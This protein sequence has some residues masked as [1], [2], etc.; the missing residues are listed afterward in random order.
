MSQYIGYTVI[1][2]SSC[3][4]HSIMTLRGSSPP[5]TAGGCL[6]F[7]GR[8]IIRLLIWLLLEYFTITISNLQS[9]LNLNRSLTQPPPPPPLPPLSAF[10][11]QAGFS[12]VSPS[13]SLSWDMRASALPPRINKYMKHMR[14]KRHG[15]YRSAVCVSDT[16]PKIF[17]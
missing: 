6:G 8:G 11:T 3:C 2:L 9:P 5:I 13:T 15:M 10:S 1:T 17:I 4:D 14:K 12:P 16:P 7:H